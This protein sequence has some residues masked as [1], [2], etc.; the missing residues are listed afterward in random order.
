[1]TK[2]TFYVQHCPMAND[3]NGADWLSKEKEIKN[4]YYGD[5]M[6]KCGMVSETITKDFK[7]PSQEKITKASKM[8]GHNH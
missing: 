7:N 4:P 2:D 3:N 5:K 1:M 6:L 8:S